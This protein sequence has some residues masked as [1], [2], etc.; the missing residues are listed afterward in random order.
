MTQQPDVTGVS[1]KPRRLFRWI[2]LAVLVA[3]IVVVGG[4]LVWAM[5]PLG[6]SAEALAAME[7]DAQVVVQKGDWLVF[8]PA[9]G[10]TTTGFVFYPGGHVDYR[11]YAPQMREL[12]AQGYLAVIA[13]MP[14]SLAVFAPG[15]AAD[16]VAA[17]PEIEQW[18]LGG[19]SL[20]GAM[21]ANFV[22]NHPDSIDG[23]ALWA[24]YPANN[25]SLADRSLPVTSVYGTNDLVASP[26]TILASAPLLPSDTDW[27]AIEGGNH[28]QFGS[29]GLQPGDGDPA[30]SASEQTTQAVAATVEMLDSFTVGG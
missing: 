22:F 21:A 11:S 7:S 12:A 15:K 9:T 13:P 19:H 6:P 14:L 2:L 28:A 30:I 25:N 18:G 1:P 23:L 8:R 29:Y 26:D 3:I 4:F 20:G 17:F 5:T 27:V 10:A 24:A 16:I